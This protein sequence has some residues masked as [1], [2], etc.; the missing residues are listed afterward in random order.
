M[1]LSGPSVKESGAAAPLLEV[2]DLVKRYDTR[3]SIWSRTVRSVRAL[4]RSRDA[5]RPGQAR[6]PAPPEG[7]RA[8]PPSLTAFENVVNRL[9]RR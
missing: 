3:A 7:E 9:A 2:R 6:G 5:S 4:D 8:A 1:T